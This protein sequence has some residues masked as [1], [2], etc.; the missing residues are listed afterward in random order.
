MYKLQAASCKQVHSQAFPLV[1]DDGEALQFLAMTT[2]LQAQVFY[3]VHQSGRRPGF[4]ATILS[5]AM[6]QWKAGTP[7]HARRSSTGFLDLK[8]KHYNATLPFVARSVADGF[9]ATHHVLCLLCTPPG[10]PY[11]LLCLLVSVG[12]LHRRVEISAVS[13]DGRKFE[14]KT[15]LGIIRL[16]R[17]PFIGQF[18]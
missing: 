11:M 9:F 4:V 5:Y 8:T 12:L 13:Y 16:T 14:K 6:S 1:L 2:P 15:L 17:Y 10:L 3:F 7:L 18:R